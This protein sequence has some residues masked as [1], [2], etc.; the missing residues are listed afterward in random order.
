MMP[1]SI[2]VTGGFG[3]LGSATA[4][5]FIAQGDRVARVD[6]ADVPAENLGSL[7]IGGVDLTVSGAAERVAAQVCDA[8][9]SH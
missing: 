6:F 4:A 1:R 5:A 8:F 2:I 7:D 3:I 9:R